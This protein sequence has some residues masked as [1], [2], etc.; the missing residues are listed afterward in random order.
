MDS[1]PFKGLHLPASAFQSLSTRA[2]RNFDLRYIEGNTMYTSP[3]MAE[4]EDS[5]VR[6]AR[7]PNGS[8]IVTP[9]KDVFL[10]TNVKNSDYIKDD[11][12]IP[13]HYVRIE[14][15]LKHIQVPYTLEDNTILRTPERILI[16]NIPDEPLNFPQPV[17]APN[18]APAI[19]SQ[20]FRGES[21]V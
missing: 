2:R 5:F 11:D 16:V 1:I 15:K 6:I 12:D 14:G 18:F 13:R 3:A 21:H 8:Y 17:Y 4:Y 10:L 7:G 20:G 9:K 19:Q